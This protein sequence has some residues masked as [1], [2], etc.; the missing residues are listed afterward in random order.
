MSSR[1]ETKNACSAA[2]KTKIRPYDSRPRSGPSHAKRRTSAT[3]DAVRV[4]L[5][6]EPPR[7]TPEA[8][9]ALLR[10]LIKASDRLH[11]ND[12]IERD[13]E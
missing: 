7:L 11:D 8:A 6:D 12:T 3:K 13:A 4:V 9:R 5:P 2:H 1:K 10:I